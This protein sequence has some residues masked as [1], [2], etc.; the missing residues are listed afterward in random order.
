MAYCDIC[1]SEDT[2]G[3]AF[4]AL[5]HGR[6]SNKGL[7]ETQKRCTIK[8]PAYKDSIG[9]ISMQYIGLHVEILPEHTIS[10][11]RSRGPLYQA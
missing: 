11:V 3:L 2:Q 1:N 4:E 6:P 5:A 7:G 8:D 10:F 9:M